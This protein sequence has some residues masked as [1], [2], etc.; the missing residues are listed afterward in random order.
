MPCVFNPGYIGPNPP[1]CD[2][3]CVVEGHCNNWECGPCPG[4]HP[5]CGCSPAP[6]QTPPSTPIQSQAQ[7]SQPN[8]S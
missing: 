1:C 4:E 6:A 3:D 7:K 8:G 2:P 5:P